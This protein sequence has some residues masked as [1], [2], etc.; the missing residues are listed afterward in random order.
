M[1]FRFFLL[2]GEGFLFSSTGGV[3]CTARSFIMISKVFMPK[4]I[5]TDMINKKAVDRK[6][7]K[8]EERIL[9]MIIFLA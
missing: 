3:F 1:L 4:T 6:P 2:G 7:A 5:M 9:N 8:K